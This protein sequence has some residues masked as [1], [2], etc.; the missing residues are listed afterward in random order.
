[1]SRLFI[2]PWLAAPT[3]PGSAWASAPR[4]TSAT[5]WLISTLPAPT[6]AGAAAATSEPTGAT[7][8]TGRSAP[9]LAG[10]VGSVAERRAHATAETVTDSG[11]FTLPG[12]CPSVPAKS[13]RMVSPATVT[14]TSTRAGACWSGPPPV[15]S[16][17]S[18]KRQVPSGTAA[19]AARMRRSP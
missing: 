2:V 14:A 8:S 15:E 13:K 11:A 6:A 4:Q 1:M 7:T 10:I 9:P 19:S 3:R 5:R 16:T 17:T 18:A 12:R